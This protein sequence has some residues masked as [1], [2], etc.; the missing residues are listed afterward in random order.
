MAYHLAILH[1]PYLSRILRGEKT[2]ESR[3]LKRRVAPYGRVVAGDMIY[4]KQAS[5]PIVATAHAAHVW[6]FDDL[7]PERADQLLVQFGDRLCLEYDFADHA[8]GQCYAVLIA[9]K[10]VR[11]LLPSLSF[12]QRGRSGWIVLDGKLQITDK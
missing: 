3:W 6:Q 12:R 8:R 7:T 4:L 10:D 1:E 11:E 9:L 2:I 5:G